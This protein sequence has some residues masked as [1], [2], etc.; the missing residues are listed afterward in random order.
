MSLL[1]DG[2][3]ADKVDLGTD[4]SLELDTVATILLWTRPTVLPDSTLRF[5]FSKGPVAT[6]DIAFNSSGGI[7]ALVMQRDRA[8]TNSSCQA[9]WSNVPH[10]SANT[11]MF[12]AGQYDANGSDADQRIFGGNLTNPADEVSTYVSQAVGSGALSSL[13][14]LSAQ[15]GNTDSGSFSWPGEI[16]W[17]YVWNRILSL[18]EIRFQ[19]FRPAFDTGCVLLMHCG[20]P[21]NGVGTQVDLSGQGNDGTITGA[22]QGSLIPLPKWFNLA[23]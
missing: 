19:Q 21:G 9:D 7:N 6:N 4:A 18:S 10:A 11:W 5:L 2:G 17:V 16:A 23:R 14:G 8:T 20:G 15:I 12:L 22:T 13:S 3:D 1:F